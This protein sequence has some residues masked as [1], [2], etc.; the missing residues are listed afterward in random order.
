MMNPQRGISEVLISTSVTDAG[1]AAVATWDTDRGAYGQIFCIIRKEVTN[2]TVT[3]SLL[4]DDTTTVSNFATVVADVTPVS[5]NAVNMVRYEVDRR[6]RQR[7][8]RLTVTSGTASNNDL[9]VYAV[10]VLHN[11]FEEPGST[12]EMN[13]STNDTAVIVT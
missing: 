5:G 1:T 13:A 10:G 2:S 4:E 11:A 8:L 7:Y 6:G 12:T 3:V 9:T